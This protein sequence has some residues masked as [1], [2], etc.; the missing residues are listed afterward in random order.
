[1]CD[2]AAVGGWVGGG[3]GGGSSQCFSPNWDHHVTDAKNCES[4]SP[5]N[6]QKFGSG[7][8]NRIAG[9][10]EYGHEQD[11]LIRKEKHRQRNC[12]DHK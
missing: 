2:I 6:S 10:D 12:H 4:C 9:L 7:E 8:K 3:E 1:M 11:E 5:T